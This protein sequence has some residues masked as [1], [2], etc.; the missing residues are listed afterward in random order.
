M[1][2]LEDKVAIVTGGAGG[3]GSATARRLASEG[4]R[5]VVADINLPQASEVADSIGAPALAL[6]YDAADVA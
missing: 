3:I 5:V 4:A 1:R 2:R 6:A